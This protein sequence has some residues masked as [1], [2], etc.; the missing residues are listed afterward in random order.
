MKGSSK[1]S[2]SS[3]GC[4]ADNE[5]WGQLGRRSDGVVFNFWEISWSFSHW[6]V[7]LH[8]SFQICFLKAW[9]IHI[10]IWVQ[11]E[12]A[13]PVE[14]D[15]CLLI[16]SY[17]SKLNLASKAKSIR[18]LNWW[19]AE[20]SPVNII[21]TSLICLSSKFFLRSPVVSADRR[22]V[23]SIQ[24]CVHCSWRLWHIFRCWIVSCSCC[25][26]NWQT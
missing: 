9:I 12:C 4:M 22:S 1:I 8:L 25:L 19:E 26:Q 13:F 11:I 18:L 23:K 16:F 21:R 5:L 7:L 24:T 17:V 14:Q 15:R 6:A 20:E 2:G 3:I 10:S